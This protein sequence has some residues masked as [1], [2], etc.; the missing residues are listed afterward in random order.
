MK[1]SKLVEM[2]REEYAKLEETKELDELSDVSFKFIHKNIKT[3]EKTLE[4]I[5]SNISN[6]KA[7]KKLI[8]MINVL[9]KMEHELKHLLGM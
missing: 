2:I 6:E 7:N 5:R 9:Y 3:L 4:S 1:R 8:K